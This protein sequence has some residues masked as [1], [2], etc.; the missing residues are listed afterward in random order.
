VEWRLI[1]KWAAKIKNHM[2]IHEGAAPT[3]SGEV[4]RR[5]RNMLMA[6]FIRRIRDRSEAEDL[7]QEVLARGIGSFRAGHEHYGQ[8]LFAIAANLLRDRARKATSHHKKAHFSISDQAAGADQIAG[9]DF[10]PE[11]VLIGKE[12]LRA[13]LDALMQLDQRTRE[14]FV[15]FRFERKKQ[16]EIAA[17]YGIS[18]SAVEKHVVKAAS[19]LAIRLNEDV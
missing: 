14:I 18:V 11:R 13:L 2:S 10:D 15:L 3:Y 6:F 16:R 12:S 5:W 19:H 9:G 17:L 1:K 7:T 8:Y 4:D